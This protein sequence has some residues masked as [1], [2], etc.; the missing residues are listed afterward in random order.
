[1]DA[2]LARIKELIAQKE[3]VDAELEKLIGSG[4]PVKEVKQRVC[5]N[6][7]E[8]GHNSAGCPQKQLPLTNGG[9]HG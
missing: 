6:C 4:A 5:K 1:M 2:K 9:A 7:G 8:P 3:S